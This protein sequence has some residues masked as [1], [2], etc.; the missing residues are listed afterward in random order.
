MEASGVVEAPG[1]PLLLCVAS[2]DD[3]EPPASVS[4]HAAPASS[5]TQI[6]TT[7][8]PRF[9]TE[10]LTIPQLS[11]VQTKLRQTNPPNRQIP[12]AVRRRSGPDHNARFSG[13]NP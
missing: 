1:V 10:P 2:G 13:G 9:L 3:G 7:A 4:L 5:I 12:A 11:P 6:P 8:R